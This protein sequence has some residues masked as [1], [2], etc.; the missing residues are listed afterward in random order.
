MFFHDSYGISSRSALLVPEFTVRWQTK[1]SDWRK[2]EI[3]FI[4]SDEKP[5]HVKSTLV[6]IKPKRN[7]VGRKVIST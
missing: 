4:R 5:V 1:T 7:P 6:N 2:F 3:K